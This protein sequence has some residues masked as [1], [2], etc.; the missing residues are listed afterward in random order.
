MLNGTRSRTLIAWGLVIVGLFMLVPSL[1]TG[2]GAPA[3]RAGMTA[4]RLTGIA[5]SSVDAGSTD[6]LADRP[7][8]LIFFA[9]W[10]HACRQ[11]L[12]RIPQV[13]HDHP[14]LRVVLVSDEPLEPVRQY[15]RGVGIT[16]PV[17]ADASE[18]F[19]S[20]GVRAVPTTVVVDAGGIVQFAAAGGASIP[21]GLE[22]LIEVAGS[23]G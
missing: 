13:L 19:S 17:A 1:K 3:V 10:C 22:R 14:G 16:L 23:G 6:P 8:A 20:Y 7:H 21:E 18:I 11:E 12:P 5:F 9:T 4:P 2:C 15:L